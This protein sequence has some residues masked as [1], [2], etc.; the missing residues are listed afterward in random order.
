MYFEGLK[1]AEP[2]Q[3]IAITKSTYK[4][5]QELFEKPYSVMYKRQYPEFFTKENPSTLD[6]M[7]SFFELMKK[8]AP[9]NLR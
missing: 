3:D 7:V 6:M 8:T 9:V 1:D 2:N 5:I 4:V